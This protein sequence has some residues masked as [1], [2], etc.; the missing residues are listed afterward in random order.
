METPES[1][2]AGPGTAHE[3]N[4]AGAAVQMFGFG[5]LLSGE[6]DRISMSSADTRPAQTRCDSPQS[7]ER[8]MNTRH[9]VTVLLALTLAVTVCEPARA[10]SGQPPAARSQS[11]A[12]A[13]VIPREWLTHKTTI[14]EAE[15]KHM[16]RDK[17]LGPEPVPFG[18]IHD[19]WVEFK[20]RFRAGDELWEFSSPGKSW[21]RLA[22]RAG[23]CIVRKGRIIESIITAMN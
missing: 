14:E 19:R 12:D 7:K 22:G 23:Y 9:V 16:V 13:D 1:F 10:A 18:F 20:S 4:P 3:V 11:K 2:C 5:A 17:K 15:R 21:S 8:L 6:D